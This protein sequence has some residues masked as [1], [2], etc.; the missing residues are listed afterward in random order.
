MA[1]QL[2]KVHF[3]LDS[4]DW[5]GHAG[6]FLWAAPL[7]PV[8]ETRV[9]IENSPFFTMGINYRDVVQI[10]ATDDKAVFAFER[11]VERSGH[12]TFMVLVIPDEPKFVALW[13]E[14]EEMGCSYE[15]VEIRL[16]M[17]RRVLLSVDVPASADIGDVLAVLVKGEEGAVWAFQDGFVFRV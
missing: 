4:R 9:R 3:S 11:V 10:Q 2:C 8:D 1:S 17:G 7:S 14:L 5:H 13:S 15:R 16:S 6:E 12:S